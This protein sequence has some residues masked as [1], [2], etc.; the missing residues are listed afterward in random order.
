MATPILTTANYHAY[1]QDTSF[2]IGDIDTP[3]TVTETW[4]ITKKPEGG[5][6]R[7][8]ALAPEALSGGEGNY[9]SLATERVIPYIGLRYFDWV[10][11]TTA[12]ARNPAMTVGDSM[13]KLTNAR[14]VNVD[15]RKNKDGSLTAISTFIQRQ[16]TIPSTINDGSPSVI[17]PPQVEYTAT[18]REMETFRTGNFT[19]PPANSNKSSSNIGG[20][21]VSS[22]GRQGMPTP[23]AGVR[24]RVR[25]VFTV[26]FATSPLQTVA[27]YLQGQVGKRNS[28]TFLGM[29]A[30]ECVFEGFN[31]AKL[32][33]PFYE[34][35]ADFD[36]DQY[37]GHVQ[38]PEL[39]PDGLPKTDGTGL[40]YNDIRWERIKRA[41]EDFNNVIFWY[42]IPGTLN[43]DMK[44]VAETGYW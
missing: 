3:T 22:N 13:D 28:A 10:E 9:G 32:E 20:D 17:F 40:N 7:F 42:D 34:I 12:V 19:A 43:N 5:A 38:V 18:V 33:G 30:G 1:L 44:T 2:S 37:Y 4:L 39:A 27:Y 35:V 8:F 25:R 29:G 26:K 6:T 16:K 24:I 31:I 21:K 36:W 23:V 15:I 14:C 41:T 11:G